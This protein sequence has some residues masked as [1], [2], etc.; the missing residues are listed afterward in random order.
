[1]VRYLTTNGKSYT[2]DQ[3]NPFTLRYPRV[4]E[5]FYDSINL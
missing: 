3:Y 4:N 2:Y 5:T 1:M